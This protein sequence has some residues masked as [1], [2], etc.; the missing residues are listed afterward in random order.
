[1]QEKEFLKQVGKRIAKYRKDRGMTQ[2]ELSDLCN[3][4]Q[5]ALARLESGNSNVTA[6]TLRKVGKV[7]EVPVKKFFDFDS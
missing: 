7:L 4:E 3:M 5:S 1:M 2:V 6:L